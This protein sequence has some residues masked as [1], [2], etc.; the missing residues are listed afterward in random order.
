MFYPASCLR[1]SNR[2]RDNATST[3]FFKLPQFLA[4]ADDIDKMGLGQSEQRQHQ[5][6]K[7]QQYQIFS[8]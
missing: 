5:K 4:Y 3:I 1:K 8:L 2:D 6:Q 7:Q